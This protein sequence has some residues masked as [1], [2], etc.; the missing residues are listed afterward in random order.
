MFA[1]IG[2]CNKCER[3]EARTQ[4]FYFFGNLSNFRCFL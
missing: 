3:G 4:L 1:F 2:F